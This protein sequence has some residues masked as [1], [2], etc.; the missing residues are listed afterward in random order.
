MKRH[1]RIAILALSAGLLVAGTLLA[2]GTPKAVIAEPILDVGVV[3]KGE[4]IVKEFTLKNEGDAPLEISEVRAA[5]GC[6]VADYTKSIP[7][8]G[9]GTVKV[10]V[11][12][13]EFNGPIAKGVTIYTNDAD[14]PQLE[15]TVRARI[16]PHIFVKPGY[17]RY[18]VVQGEPQEGTIGQTLYA[19]NGT[20]FDVLDVQ[21]PWPHLAVKFREATPQERNADAAGKQWRVETTLSNN[22]PVGPLS[23]FVVINTNHP[24]QKIVQIPVS[25]FVR[26]TIAVTPPSGDFG[27][28]DV[29][30][31]TVQRSLNVRNFA[32]EPIKVT[33]VESDNQNLAVSIDP[34]QEGREYTLRITVK[35]EMAKGPFDSK[36]VIRTD[37]PKA[38]T[39]EVDV[40]GTV[41]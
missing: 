25:G 1:A 28:I 13:T 37:S 32:T 11:E 34:V 7:P 19:P 15:L 41:I 18:I 17:A 27:K 20:S 3:A 39:L 10:T 14:N 40:R 22:A 36:L 12:T 6:T 8:G 24:H 33:G 35:S 23:D 29:K 5:C 9:T 38:P 26:P 30:G 31:Q 21:S 4:K 16:E 2:Q